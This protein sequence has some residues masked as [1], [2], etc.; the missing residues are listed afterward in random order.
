[1]EDSLR[2]ACYRFHSLRTKCFCLFLNA[3]FP[4]FFKMFSTIYLRNSRSLVDLA[5]ILSC[6]VLLASLIAVKIRNMTTIFHIAPNSQPRQSYRIRKIQEFQP[7]QFFLQKVGKFIIRFR[8]F[9]NYCIPPHDVE[10]LMTI[11]LCSCLTNFRDS[12]YEKK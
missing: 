6:A 1:M 8:I 10:Q 9:F 4:K 2:F 7:F 12:S 11:I 3:C 5:G